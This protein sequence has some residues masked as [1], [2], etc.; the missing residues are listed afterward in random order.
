M[1][2]LINVIS[3][4]VETIDKLINQKLP[5]NG[6]LY[7]ETKNSG[8]LSFRPKDFRLKLQMVAGD[9]DINRYLSLFKNLGLIVSTEKNTFTY[10]QRHKKKVLRVITIERVKF[11]TLKDLLSGKVE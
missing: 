4:Y 1:L 5:G 6:K 2:E 10:V 3:V 9:K 11:E 7:I 8:Y